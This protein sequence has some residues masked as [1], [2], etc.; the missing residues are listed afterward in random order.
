MIHRL[1]RLGWFAF[2]TP[3]RAVTT[4]TLYLAL[5]AAARL[6][7]LPGGLGYDDAEQVLSAQSWALVYR[8]EQPPLWTWLLKLLAG[9]LG[10]EP[11]LL[12]LTLLRA[13]TLAALYLATYLA[14][15]QWLDDHLTSAVAAASLSGTYTLGWL[16]F[17]D[18]PHSTLLAVMVAAALWCWGRLIERPD[19]ARTLSFAVVCGLGLLAKWNFVVLAAGFALVGV[20]DPRLRP[21]VL[22]WRSP[23]IALVAGLIALPSAL[24]VVLQ[25]GSPMGLATGVLA[26]PTA[27]GWQLLALLEAALAFPQPWLALALI[28][29]WPALQRPRRGSG[30]LLALIAIVLA[31]HAALIPL[32]GANTFPERWMI[33]P[34]LPL[35]IFMLASVQPLSPRVAALGGVLVMLAAA[36]LILRMG[37]GLTDSH[38]CGKCRT[39]IPAAA[40]ASALRDAGF[41][42]GTIVV[43]D[44]HLGGN[45]RRQLPEA[46][47]VALGFPPGAWPP[48]RAGQCVVAWPAEARSGRLLRMTEQLLGAK[49]QD[50]QPTTVSAPLLGNVERRQAMTF[51]LAP[52]RGDCR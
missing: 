23:L 46:R 16:A 39:R 47:V 44:M 22:S 37:V 27:A 30:R 25:H 49:V 17:G 28:V 31:L 11:D 43:N 42:G 38:Y 3:A 35:P 1:H 29:L 21:L 2:G 6:W 10:E 51:V 52:G 8:F 18:L 33:V 34:L 5:H 50:M 32:A 41:E 4:L 13:L 20:L 19:L 26:E 9:T 48:P 36:T 24:A 15:R 40:F 7:L 45:L 12:T 14:A